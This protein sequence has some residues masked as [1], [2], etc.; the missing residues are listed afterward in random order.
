[1]TLPVGCLRRIRV[2]DSKVPHLAGSFRIGAPAPG[3]GEGLIRGD[4]ALHVSG[5]VPLAV[6][7]ESTGVG[8]AGDFSGASRLVFVRLGSLQHLV[9]RHPRRFHNLIYEI[10]ASLGR[11]WARGR[12]RL[13]VPCSPA[14]DEV[15]DLVDFDL[16]GVTLLAVLRLGDLAALNLLFQQSWCGTFRLRGRLCLE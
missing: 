5:R 2:V 11:C 10:L 13:P 8:R 16:G 12:P 6:E 3:H 15:V 1:M 14:L 7:Y 4:Y 9:V